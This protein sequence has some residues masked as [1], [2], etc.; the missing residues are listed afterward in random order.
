MDSQDQR[1]VLSKVLHK[2]RTIVR[3]LR[4][5][6]FI[7]LSLFSIVAFT[8]AFQSVRLASLIDCT[9]FVSPS[10]SAVMLMLSGILG[11]C[12]WHKAAFLLPYSSRVVSFVDTNFFTFTQNELIIIN[13]AIGIVAALFII[14]AFKHFFYG[15]EWS[16]L[17]ARS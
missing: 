12:N 6:P 8:S 7:Y 1:A 3:V 9:L 5:L 11:M 2:Y 17:Q 15:K 14:L 16:R 10:M 13:C 4:I